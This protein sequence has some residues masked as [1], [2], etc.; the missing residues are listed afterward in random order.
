[1]KTLDLAVLSAT[2]GQT[3]INNQ[4][5][6]LK[7]KV[8]EGLIESGNASSIVKYLSDDYSW[9]ETNL[10][11]PYFS[12]LINEF[13]SR[14]AEYRQG[15]ATVQNL[16]LP[17]SRFY[18]SQFLFK[19]DIHLLSVYIVFHRTKILRIWVTGWRRMHTDNDLASL[20]K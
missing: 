19:C 6:Q 13:E 7:K 16:L 4:I 15:I 3:R 9:R 8:K 18:V 14:L 2:N 12:N 5:K 10:P 1:V 20:R 17:V 11:S